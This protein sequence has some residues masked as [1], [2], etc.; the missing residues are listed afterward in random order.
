MNSPPRQDNSMLGTSNVVMLVIRCPPVSV[1][2][3][4][5]VSNCGGCMMAGKQLRWVPGPNW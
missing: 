3:L 4:E 5:S 1:E 2:D